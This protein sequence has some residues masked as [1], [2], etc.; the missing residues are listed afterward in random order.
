L[1]TLAYTWL[2]IGALRR[3]EFRSHMR[4]I[5]LMMANL[6]TAPV[7][8]SEWALF[9]M[10]T[11]LDMSAVNQGATVFLGLTT[12]LMM[13]L[14]MEGIGYADPPARQRAAVLAPCGIDLLAG[15]RVAA[16]LPVAAVAWSLPA[17]ALA[18]RAPRE[19]GAATAGAHVTTA[20]Q[21]L[22]A[23]AAVGALRAEI[24]RNPWPTKGRATAGM[25]GRYLGIQRRVRFRTLTLGTGPPL[26]VA[27]T[28]DRQRAAHPGHRE[29]VAMCG[30]PGVLHRD[31]FAKY[32]A[33]FFTISRSS[34][35]FA[36]SRRRRALSAS[37]SLAERFTGSSAPAARSSSPG[38]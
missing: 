35:A 12:I 14:W 18:W 28:R 10:L 30:Y 5:A 1:V 2:A 3:R 22:A 31:S 19:I 11:P 38:R 37:S 6:L 9:G 7:P 32:G 24:F 21:I 36:N 34:F 15:W 33:A 27:T 23:L 13:A 16:S 26:A 20:S 8:R 29:Q 25:G 17:M 4:F